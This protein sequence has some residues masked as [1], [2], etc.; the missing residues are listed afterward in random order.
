MCRPTSGRASCIK[1]VLAVRTARVRLRSGRT[2]PR[3]L[4]SRPHRLRH[5]RRSIHGT[6][7][8][9]GCAGDEAGAGRCGG[10]L[11]LHPFGPRIR[12]RPLEAAEVFLRLRDGLARPLDHLVAGAPT[13]VELVAA[14]V[15]RCAA[16]FLTASAGLPTPSGLALAPSRAAKKVL[17]NLLL[18]CGQ[19][20]RFSWRFLALGTPPRPQ[21]NPD[22][23]LF[24]SSTR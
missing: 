14:V 3:L 17:T 24:S 22:P 5:P 7:R 6:D 18:Q 16:D 20:P 21:P 8:R 23:A 19:K 15:R 13:F 11:R 2:T 4:T 10:G 9:N 1:T 12:D